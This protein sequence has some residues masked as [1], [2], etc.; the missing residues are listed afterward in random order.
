MIIN[1]PISAFNAY[2]NNIQN[3]INKRMITCFLQCFGNSLLQI[4]L[5]T[6]LVQKLINMHMVI[7]LINTSAFCNTFLTL[8][9]INSPIYGQKWNSS[10]LNSKPNS[11]IFNSNLRELLIEF[12]INTAEISN[13]LFELTFKQNKNYCEF[14][15]GNFCSDWLEL[16]GFFH[17]F[18]QKTLT[19]RTNQKC[20]W[21]FLFDKQNLTNLFQKY[22]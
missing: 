5:Q 17:F 6:N 2:I 3:C 16:S 14:L 20:Y 12:L 18:K 1:L 22:L 21:C 4:H 19:I 8:S 11:N 9:H 15:T 13:K 10:L 7:I